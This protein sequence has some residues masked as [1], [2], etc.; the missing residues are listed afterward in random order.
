MKNICSSYTSSRREK[1]SGLHRVDLLNFVTDFC[2]Q[3][4][5]P[6]ASNKG[7]DGRRDLIEAYVALQH[8]VSPMNYTCGVYIVVLH[9]ALERFEATRK[10]S[11]NPN[12]FKQQ[13]DHLNRL[14]RDNDIDCH[15][16]L[17][18]NRHT[19]LRLC[20][21]I[22]T[23]G[24]SDSK[25]VVLEE[26][27]IMFLT[28]LGHHHKNRNV[29]FNFM[30]SGQT[31]SK[32]FND[33]LKAVLQLQGVLL[34]TPEPITTGCT[35]DKW[36]WFQN[37]LGA[38]DGTYVRVL[39][40]AVDK[41]RYR[42]R[43]GEIATNVLGVCS[44]DMQFIYV[45][46]G[47]EGSASDS[48]VIRDA[49]SRPN[50]LRVPTGSYYLVDA[51]YTN[52]DGF[53]AP[54]R[55]QR[56]HLSTWR[57]GGAPTNPEEF[58]NMKHSAMP[59]DPLEVDLDDTL[60][61][62]Q[63]TGD[64]YIDIIEGSDQWSNWR[65]TL[66]NQMYNEWSMDDTTVTSGCRKKGKGKATASSSRGH[67]VWTP[68]ECDVL[69]QAMRDLFSENW[70]TDNGQF[71]CGFYSE[72]EKLIILAFPGTNLRASP[73]IESKIK[74]WRRQYNFLTDMLRLSGFGW[75]DSEKMILVDSD[76]VWQNYV[77]PD[78]KGMRNVPFI[79]YKDWVILFGKDRATGVLAEGP[80][81][82]V[83][84]LEKEDQTTE[85]CYTPIVDLPDCPLSASG[86]P[87]NQGGSGT[88]FKKRAREAEGIAKG[89]VDM[90]VEFGSFFKKTNITMQEIA[91]RIGYAQDLS[92][93]RKLVNGALAKLRLNTNGRLRAATLIVKDAE[94]VDLFFSLPEEEE[95]K[96]VCLLLA[97]CV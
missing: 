81:D 34:K 4:F 63:E 74:F 77:K 84:A 2:W 60:P 94:R 67:R 56:Y 70:K 54:Y 42:S 78:A 49:I 85:E 86:T 37:C 48:R 50:G 83:D 43:K 64:E 7:F 72:L 41:A 1:G 96:W 73:Y 35:D 69:I 28:V 82:M 11:R 36:R 89:L 76:Q 27:V 3:D 31:V 17:R 92:Q 68:K 65:D 90:A 18:M 57:E 16:Q 6:M 30:R 26:K 91:H 5:I 14:V 88:T 25:Y 59:M 21:L 61:N 40:P 9:A 79:Y 51:G 55:G 58:F 45:L 75:D 12:P 33:V 10:I 71:R 52:G 93:S 46:P 95:M 32:Y 15:E 8:I 62:N 53:L 20:G 24:V 66:A 47:W 80:A 29:K 44:H 38:L 19:F 97:G 23:K 22:R 87:C 13:L 39:A